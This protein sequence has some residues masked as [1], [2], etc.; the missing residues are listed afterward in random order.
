MKDYRKVIITHLLTEKISVAREKQNIYVFQVARD[1]NKIDIK[2]AIERLFNV[3]VDG[4]RTMIIH[5]KIKRLGRF[6]GKRPNWKKAIVN[7][8]AGDTISQL[9]AL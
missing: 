6:T 8:K 5:G 7:L 4:V 1:A 2:E 9:D 3:K